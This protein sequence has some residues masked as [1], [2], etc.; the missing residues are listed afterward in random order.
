MLTSL[1][2]LDLPPAEI[3]DVHQLEEARVLSQERRQRVPVVAL[4]EAVEEFGPS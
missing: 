4:E 2:T 3:D 1:G